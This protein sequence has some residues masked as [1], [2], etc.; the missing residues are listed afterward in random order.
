MTAPKLV[1][2]A[3]KFWLKSLKKFQKSLD[4]VY[5]L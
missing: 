1:F 3:V 5:M 4:K 2:G